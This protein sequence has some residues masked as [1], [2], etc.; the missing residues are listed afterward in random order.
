MPHDCITDPKDL[1]REIEVF[2]ERLMERRRFERR[3][4]RWTAAVELR[5]QRFEGVITDLS[6]GGARIKFDA[7]VE[8]GDELR[9]VLHHLS[10]LGARVVWQRRGEA[11]L[12]FLL[13]PQ[14][15]ADR[16]RP[17]AVPAPAAPVE[18]RKP[19]LRAHRRAWLA[20]SIAAGL[21]VILGSAALAGVFAAVPSP[22]PEILARSIGSGEHGC[23]ARI[24]KITA[25]TNQIDFSLSVAS[26]AE[27]KC[28][29][30]H[31]LDQAGND[32]RGHMTQATKVPLR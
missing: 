18:G 27:A 14:E 25:A 13:A 29:D 11:G 31:H 32:L 6:P 7:A 12:S 23:A 30:L 9:L 22:E 10:E 26:A 5:G 15:V 8:K 19:A 4:V 16:L 24:G 1:L 2:G 21:C 3:G 20:A 28:L 17:K